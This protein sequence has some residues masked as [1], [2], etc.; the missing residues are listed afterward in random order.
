MVLVRVG[1]LLALAVEVGSEADV[2]GDRAQR[3]HAAE[4][5]QS[6][7][8][9]VDPGLARWRARGRRRVE[10]GRRR[11]AGRGR[12]GAA[13]ALAADHHGALHAERHVDGAEEREGAGRGELDRALVAGLAHLVDA[14]GGAVELAVASGV[15]AVARGDRV[16]G[17]AL[18]LERDRLTGLDVDVS[19]L[20]LE[21]RGALYD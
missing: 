6:P 8:G 10:H 12:A 15:R 14:A 21:R 19:R 2:G 13:A 18:D 1:R 11:R 4:R 5:Q 17:A 20:P 16:R 7:A 9:V 3:D